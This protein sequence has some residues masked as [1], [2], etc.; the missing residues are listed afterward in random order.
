[1]KF[2]IKEKL[3]RINPIKKNAD[4]KRT[5]FGKKEDGDGANKFF[6]KVG[7]Y[8][9]PEPQKE[10]VLSKEDFKGAGDVYFASVS[11]FAKKRQ[12]HSVFAHVPKQRTVFKLF[13]KG[14]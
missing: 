8:F 6:D 11:A 9:N 5:F 2:N 12:Q 4:G 3:D 1:M 14:S 10:R 13:Q 7:D